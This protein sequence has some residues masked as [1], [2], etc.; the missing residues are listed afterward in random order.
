MQSCP[1]TICDAVVVPGSRTTGDLS[2][3]GHKPCLRG[4]EA[5]NSGAE[6]QG[7]RF[8]PWAPSMASPTSP[9]PLPALFHRRRGPEMSGQKVLTLLLLL[10]ELCRRGSAAVGREGAMALLLRFVPPQR[11]LPWGSLLPQ[12]WGVALLGGAGADAALQNP[13][14]G[15][16][17][18]PG[19][20]R[21][22]AGLGITDAFGHCG[23]FPDFL[24][25]PKPGVSPGRG[26]GY[27]G[28]GGQRDPGCAGAGLAV[29]HGRADVE[30]WGT[31]GFL[32]REWSH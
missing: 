23:M 19:F 20:R 32:S 26:V 6:V 9:V 10:G 3:P 2:Q 5:D 22:M 21:A 18:S 27:P 14:L 29:G 11:G 13:P 7:S 24:F 16:T 25:F 4:W 30:L 28:P 8:Q 17:D 12:L 31:G 15:S 1:F